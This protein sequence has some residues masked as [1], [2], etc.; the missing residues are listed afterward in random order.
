MKQS[1]KHLSL[2][3]R[4]EIAVWKV[5][6]L[7]MR[8]V[9]RRLDRDVSSISRELKRNAPPLRPGR[10]LPAR[11]H[12]RSTQRNQLSRTHLRLKN[13]EIR[14]LVLR[15]LQQ[16][17]SPEQIAGQLRQEK[18]KLSIS[19]EAIYQFIYSE[20]RNLI[21]LLARSHRKRLQRWHSHK[22]RKSHIPQ[23]TPITQRPAIVQTRRQFG[24]WEADTI[25]SRKSKAS[26][27]VMV[28]RKSRLVKLA[29]LP[30]KSA[31]K[32]RA[33]INRRLTLFSK[34]LRR[35]ITYDNGSENIEHLQ[36]NNLLGTRSFFCLPFHSW[37]KG[38][39]EN[40]NGLV[41]RFYPK[42]TDFANI[43]R[44]QVRRVERIL[45]SRPRKCLR[46]KTPEQVF[47]LGVA[48]TG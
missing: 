42:K 1:Y 6:G 37:E 18:S 20:A 27:L 31:S 7:S 14:C 2:A 19:H 24:H 46:F 33:A 22:H 40:T 38:T 26:L 39:V 30:Q 9:S 16:G 28:E 41:R 36:V 34:G 47:R 11:A 5:E 21:P 48:L 23:R 45:N 13:P 12:L 32:T 10:Y 25:I 35:T 29:W 44:A 8:E 43:T 3:E 17:L 15:K 4:E